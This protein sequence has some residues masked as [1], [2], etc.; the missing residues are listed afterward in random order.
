MISD[1]AGI[2]SD[3]NY[4]YYSYLPYARLLGQNTSDSSPCFIYGNIKSKH[5]I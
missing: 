4:E 3:P 2:V 5:L 1:S